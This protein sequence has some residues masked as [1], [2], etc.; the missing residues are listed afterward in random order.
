MLTEK[1]MQDK[2]KLFKI[3][4]DLTKEDLSFLREYFDKSELLDEANEVIINLLNFDEEKPFEFKI[5]KA[6]LIVSKYD[7]KE[8]IDLYVTKDEMSKLYDL[9]GGNRFIVTL[10]I[11]GV[12]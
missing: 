11:K 7:S 6:I 3:F 8:L 5:K 12:G 4:S 9:V 10:R 2:Q 1:S